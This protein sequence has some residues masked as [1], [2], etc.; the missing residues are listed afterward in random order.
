MRGGAYG[1]SASPNGL[2]GTFSFSS[3]RDPNI[4]STLDAFREGLQQARDDALQRGAGR[5]GRDRHGGARGAAQLPRR[6]GDDLAE[7]GAAGDQ[8][9]GLRQRRRD[10]LLALTPAQLSQAAARLLSGFEEGFT[11]VLSSRA[12][13]EE[14]A[15]VRPEL[16]RRIVELAGVAAVLP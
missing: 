5:A 7:E 2:E 9:T 12:A 16:G 11:V 4:L 6:E 15:R 13:V 14:A 10:A 3:Y 8:T 1:A